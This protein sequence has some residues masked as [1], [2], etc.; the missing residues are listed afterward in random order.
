MRTDDGQALGIASIVSRM[1]DGH[2]IEACPTPQELAGWIDTLLR[3]YGCDVRPTPDLAPHARFGRQLEEDWSDTGS[4]ERYGLRYSLM[5]AE[6]TFRRLLDPHPALDPT[7]LDSFRSI[8]ADRPSPT[9]DFY[10]LCI[11]PESSLRRALAIKHELGRGMH[12]VLFV[13]DDDATSIAL[14]LLEPS[15]PLWVI[16]IDER[17]LDFLRSA[18]ERLEATLRTEAVDVRFAIPL[19]LKARFSGVVL[20]PPRLFKLCL[21]FLRFS[22]GCLSSIAPARMF[23]SDHPEATLGFDALL[24]AL[25]SLDLSV[26]AVYPELHRY[27]H[28]AMRSQIGGNESEGS[29]YMELL[30]LLS[31]TFRLDPLWL[32]SLASF[33][34]PWSH[35]YVLGRG[36]GLP[37]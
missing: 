20:D 2:A 9:Q 14:A 6:T 34:Q 8:L 21:E 4:A 22:V 37:R 36:S 32:R 30:D 12:S 24:E 28:A 11:D 13:G 18:A 5:M 35:L 16:D 3:R 17:F 23:W 7:L 15:W 29:D 10:Q 27:N 33:T 25:P 19:H 31:A 26:L 1:L